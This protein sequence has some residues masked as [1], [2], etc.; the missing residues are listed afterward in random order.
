MSDSLLT[1][2]SVNWSRR[3]QDSARACDREDEELKM[4]AILSKL[5]E[6]ASRVQPGLAV[7]VG[8]GVALAACALYGTRE[9]KVAPPCHNNNNNYKIYQTLSSASRRSGEP[10]TLDS[11]G[12][13][14]DAWPSE[15]AGGTSR[16]A[17][18][19]GRLSNRLPFDTKAVYV[20][21]VHTVIASTTSGLL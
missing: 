21:A 20:P 10:F 12:N 6:Q 2:P 8:V 3:F 16:P 4:P 9:R 19:R 18:G 14:L 5:R 15:T 13:G 7:G 11:R 1:L 17:P